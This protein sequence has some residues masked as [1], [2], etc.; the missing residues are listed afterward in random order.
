MMSNDKNKTEQVIIFCMEDF[1]PEDHLLRKIEE[2]I[3]F[4]RPFQILCKL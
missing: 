1:V 4:L 3:D 2:A